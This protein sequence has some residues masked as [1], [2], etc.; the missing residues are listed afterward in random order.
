VLIYRDPRAAHNGSGSVRING[1]AG[2]ALSGALLFPAAEVEYS[3]N[4]GSGGCTMLVAG[5]VTI[6]GNSDMAVTRC[7]ELG[8]ELPRASF[9]RLA[10]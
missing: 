6:T 7:A 9:V 10:E 8:T 4:S 5:S 2:I 1:G 3:G